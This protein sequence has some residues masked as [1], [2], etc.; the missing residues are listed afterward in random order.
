MSQKKN[1]PDSLNQQPKRSNQD[2]QLQKIPLGSLKVETPTTGLH[3]DAW[4]VIEFEDQGQDFL[5]WQITED[6]LV[7]RSTPYQDQF[8]SGYTVEMEDL[9]IGQQPG[10]INKQG[11]LSYLKY[12]V[13][14]MQLVS[15]L[16]ADAKAAADY[17]PPLE[18]R[19]QIASL[20]TGWFMEA[21][22]EFNAE[23]ERQGGRWYTDSEGIRTEQRPRVEAEVISDNGSL[24]VLLLREATGND[25]LHLGIIYQQITHDRI[26]G[27]R[28]PPLIG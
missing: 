21:V 12:P 24:S 13:I 2:G 11:K 25:V 8:W 3:P 5:H 28:L 14:K 20:G 6:G 10:I 26:A 7:V 1:Q 23:A 9:Y 22:A 27:N 15:S 18:C 16:L 17:P 4:A 19:V